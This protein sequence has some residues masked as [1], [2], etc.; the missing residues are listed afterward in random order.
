LDAITSS[1]NFLGTDRIGRPL[2]DAESKA[3]GALLRKHGF[4]P[5]SRIALRFAYKK[6]GSVQAAQDLMGRT[7]LRFIR[8]GWDPN[9]VTLT[10]RLCRVVWS[11]WTHQLEETK[12]AQIAEEAFIAEQVA[13]GELVLPAPSALQRGDPLHQKKELATP[14]YEQQVERLDAERQDDARRQKKLE[15]MRA[16]LSKLR[17]TLEAKGDAVNVEWLD[18]RLRGIE[19]PKDMA[20]ETGRRPEEFYAATKRRTR[21]V[22]SVLAEVTGERGKDVHEDEETS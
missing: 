5:A 1:G 18:L 11:E 6:T 20:G 12:Q 7:W 8:W 22:R 9:A 21:V 16:G 15:Q 10:K 2:T 14:S 3:L 4:K 19:D 17:T 13:A